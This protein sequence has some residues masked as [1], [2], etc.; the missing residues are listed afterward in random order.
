[1]VVSLR[2]WPP[3]TCVAYNKARSNRSVRIVTGDIIDVITLCPD[4]AM[5]H[6]AKQTK[7][8]ADTLPVGSHT[9]VLEGPHPGRAAVRVRVAHDPLRGDA[10]PWFR[11]C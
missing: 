1:M 3:C 8:P 6:A 2:T 10:N 7:G 4:K 5:G 11:D 9:G